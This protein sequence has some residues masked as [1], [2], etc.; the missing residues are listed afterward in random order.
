[1]QAIVW[2][3]LA[4]GLLGS[5]PAATFPASP[6]ALVAA[7]QAADSGTIS[8]GPALPAF[9]PAVDQGPFLTD[10][11]EPQRPR[12]I[13]Y[14]G[15]YY[16]R[17]TIHRYASYASLPL[18]VAEYFI[19]RS[20]YNNPTTSSR[21]LRSAH[22]TVATGLGAL[23]AINTVTG[24]WNLWDSRHDPAGRTRRT[25]HGLMMLAADA[26]FVATA[27]LAPNGR[28]FRGSATGTPDPSAA[29]LHRGLAIASMGLALGSSVMMLVWR[30]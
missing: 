2:V 30:P 17:L 11:S 6:P 25:V 20:L 14:S 26:G 9:V 8:A 4:T 16:T 22:T 15:A 10:A 18:F 1:M 23:F 19:G 12:A 5:T 24:V 3:V 7:A 13:E 21:S 27:M 29:N 28:D